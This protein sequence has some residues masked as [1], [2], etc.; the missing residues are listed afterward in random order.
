MNF[1][2]EV[3]EFSTKDIQMAKVQWTEQ[4]CF[5]IIRKKKTVQQSWLND[6]VQA[7]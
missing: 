2:C 1:S 6:E 7:I 3:Y 5:H 4:K